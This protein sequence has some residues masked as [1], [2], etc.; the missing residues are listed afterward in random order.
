MTQE[1]YT[2]IN[3]VLDRSG[4]M[5]KLAVETISG[6]NKFLTEQKKVDGKATLTLATFAS[7]YSLIHD[8]VP[9]DSV[10]DLTTETYKTGGYTALLDAVAMTI[11]ATGRK[12]AAMPED[13]RPRKVIFVI[14]TDGQENFSRQFDREKVFEKISHQRD[15]YSWEFVYI[16]A[17]QDAIQ[18]GIK[19]GISG[20]NSINYVADEVGTAAIFANVSNNTSTYRNNAAKQVD[21]F[22]QSSDNKSK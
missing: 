5:T 16:G 12:L 11:D 8:C 3:M 15:K 18:E 6:F 17:N 7:D 19:F 2:S 1:N 21:F 13:E 4:S 14:I 20:S 9:L 10:K 22:N